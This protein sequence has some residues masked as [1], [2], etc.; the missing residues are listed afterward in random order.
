[1]NFGEALQLQINMPEDLLEKFVTVE[2]VNNTIQWYKKKGYNI[3]TKKVQLWANYKGKRIKNGV[4]ERV[5]RGTTIQVKPKDLFPRSNKY[6]GFICNKC[7]QKSSTSWQAYQNK[8]DKNRCHMCEKKQ[9]K[10]T[11]SHH[12]W[13]EQLISKNVEAKCDISGETDKRF[14]VLHHLRNRKNGGINDPSNYV[15]LSANYHLAF[16]NW[17]GGMSVNCTSE[18][19]Y[20]FKELELGK[21]LKIV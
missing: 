18:N 17:N 20:E 8:N 3:P 9:L 11:G 2:V 12:Y 1:M 10:G 13:V 19:Y 15:I 21:K 14:L 5:Q 6:I 7:G 4:E 16:H